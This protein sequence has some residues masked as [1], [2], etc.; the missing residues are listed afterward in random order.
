MVCAATSNCSNSWVAM[1]N[2]N[3]LGGRSDAAM[4]LSRCQSVCV[5]NVDC[6]G[7]DWNPTASSG[8]RCWLTGPWSSGWRI[9][10]ATGITH[11][12]LTRAD[13]RKYAN[14]S[15][16]STMYKW[17]S[18]LQLINYARLHVYCDSRLCDLAYY[19][20]YYRHVTCPVSLLCLKLRWS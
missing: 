20:W 2:T 17:L 8:Q 13:C 1:E 7:L 4:T 12:N 16:C 10:Y 19:P 6:T 18:S 9:G 11:Y 5:N 3:V 14:M 15:S